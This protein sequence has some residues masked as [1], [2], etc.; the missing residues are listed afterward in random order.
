M[1]ANDD[2][3]GMPK[4]A[5]AA[6]EA[7]VNDEQVKDTGTADIPGD[8]V[9]NAAAQSLHGARAVKEKFRQPD[10]RALPGGS[11]L[12]ADPT[13]SDPPTAGERV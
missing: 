6:A 8:E 10:A 7:K 13:Q 4:G 9:A 11:T 3:Q 1:S 2:K 12:I 5:R